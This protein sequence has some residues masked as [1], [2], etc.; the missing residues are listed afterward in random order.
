[1][2]DVQVCA[3]RP[4]SCGGKLDCLR[5]YGTGYYTVWLNPAE[6][7][8]LIASETRQMLELLS[9]ERERA[10]KWEKAKR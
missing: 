8:T 2:N 1:M 4:C 7:T 6:L 10:A 5:C 3:R 9:V